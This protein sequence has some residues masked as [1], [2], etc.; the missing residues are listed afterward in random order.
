MLECVKSFIERIFLLR[1]SNTYIQPYQTPLQTTLF[2]Y[3]AHNRLK[4]HKLAFSLQNKA[5]DLRTWLLATYGY[6]VIIIIRCH[7]LCFRKETRQKEVH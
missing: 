2:L 5:I 7:A 4:Y 6:V 1:N 3:Y